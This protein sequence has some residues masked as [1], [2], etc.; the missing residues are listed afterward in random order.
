MYKLLGSVN[1]NDWLMIECRKYFI[2]SETVTRCETHCKRT[3]RNMRYR[4]SHSSDAVSQVSQQPEE[5][6]DSQW[7]L[8]EFSTLKSSPLDK[9]I[10]ELLVKYR[11]TQNSILDGLACLNCDPFFLITTSGHEQ[12]PVREAALVPV[13]DIRYPVVAV[14]S[15][16]YYSDQKGYVECTPMDTHPS[17]FVAATTHQ[18]KRPSLPMTVEEKEV[19]RRDQNREAQ[20]RFREKRMLSS[21]RP[22]IPRRSFHIG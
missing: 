16:Q 6:L 20:R 2:R 5:Y 14:P 1:G 17:D 12:A 22:M 19:R 7:C 3:S 13:D 4:V 15:L 10:D 11:P 8:S 21:G 9:S 18:R